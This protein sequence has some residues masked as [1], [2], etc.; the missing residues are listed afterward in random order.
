[1]FPG[2]ILVALVPDIAEAVAVLA[3][4]QALPGAIIGND[5]QTK[6]GVYLTLTIPVAAGGTYFCLGGQDQLLH[7]RSVQWMMTVGDGR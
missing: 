6:F 5:D 4:H 1:M 7:G 2:A 3:P